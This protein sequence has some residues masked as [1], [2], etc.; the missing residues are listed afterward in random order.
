VE[1]REHVVAMVVPDRHSL[2]DTETRTTSDMRLNA[3]Y[4]DRMP[5]HNSAGGPSLVHRTLCAAIVRQWTYRKP[6]TRRSG[7]A[8]AA[9]TAWPPARA[10]RDLV[11]SLERAPL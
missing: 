10:T 5:A 3:A 8:A 1:K 9:G 7:V 2:A 11:H 6:W 4:T